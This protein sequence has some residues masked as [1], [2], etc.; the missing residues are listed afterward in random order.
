MRLP[1]AGPHASGLMT[2]SVRA[3]DSKTPFKVISTL[4]G[5]FST[6]T[7][8]GFGVEPGLAGLFFAAVSASA[9]TATHAARNATVRDGRRIRRT[10]GQPS[11]VGGKRMCSIVRDLAGSR[12]GGVV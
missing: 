3:D 11:A 5:A 6:L 2:I 8:G 12:N 7:V 4:N 9:A 10:I 1:D